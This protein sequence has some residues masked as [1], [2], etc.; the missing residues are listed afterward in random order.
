MATT[1]LNNG[2][3]PDTIQNKTID[4]SN[5]I[6]T[7]TTKLTISG[8]SNGQVLSTDGSGNLSWTT[9]GAL[10]APTA[11]VTKT[12]DETVTNSTTLQDDDALYIAVTANKNYYSEVDLFVSRTGTS[13]DLKITF[14]DTI[15]FRGTFQRL[16]DSANYLPIGTT[17]TYNDTPSLTSLSYT[18]PRALKY[19]IAYLP[20]SDTTLKMQWAQTA[21]S[22]NG[23]RIHKG[24]TMRIW[25]TS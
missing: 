23:V 21:S 6:D 15:G 14:V 7:T 5:D 2:Q 20:N 18:M 22:A 19:V 16:N 25:E 4:T 12:A 17:F 11:V 3:L 9:A 10:G 1:K 13:P 8:G 24:S